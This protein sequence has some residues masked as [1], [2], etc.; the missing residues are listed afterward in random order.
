[1]QR[2]LFLLLLFSSLLACSNEAPV[3]SPLVDQRAFV[4]A[5]LT[6]VLQ[7]VDADDD[8]LRFG[9]A[10]QLEGVSSRARVS[11]ASGGKAKFHWTPLISDIGTWSFDFTVSDGEA[12]VRETIDIEV[13]LSGEGSTAPVFIQ[14]LGT[15]TTIDL[16]QQ[17]CVEFPVV[18]EDPDTAGVELGQ[19]EPLIVGAELRQTGELNGAW[20][21]CPTK[22][23]AANEDRYTL[24]LS[25]D[26]F[27]NET[28]V[29]QYLIVL[30]SGD[31]EGCPGEAP[32]VTHM[33]EGFDTVNDLT[34]TA[35]VSDDVGMKYE[36]LFYYSLTPPDNPPDL[37]AMTQ[38][39][40][41][42]LD[43]DLQ[44]GVWGAEVPNP[45]AA[46]PA[47]ASAQL[48]YIIAAQDNDDETGT[49]DHITQVPDMGAFKVTVTNPGGGG[50]LGLCEPCSADVQCGGQN[51]LCVVMGGE[52]RC[53][54]GCNGDSD[55]SEEGYY[56]SFGNMTS[57][58]N[59]SARQ[60]IPN[61]FMC[62]G[63]STVC[64]DD[65]FE[66]NDSLAEVSSGPALSVGTHNDLKSCPAASV[67]DDEDWFRLDL[68]TDTTISAAIAGGNTTDLDLALTDDQGNVI[69]TSDS[70]SST[71][72]V[73][74]CLPAGTYYLHVFAY[75]TG[76]NS[77]SLTYGETAGSCGGTCSDDGNE[78]DDSSISARSVDLNMGTYRSDTQAICSMDD[79][80][81]A[82]DMFAGEILYASLL[83]LQTSAAEDID[84]II[85][86][87]TLTNLTGCDEQ[88]PLLCDP[89]NGQSGT[90]NEFMAWP[91]SATGRYYVVIRGWNG[92]ENLYDVC[93]GLSSFSCP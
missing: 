39:S 76:E 20:S 57:V 88:N 17:S 52:P 46:E 29:K 18:V 58:D 71:E 73:A 50:G 56:C 66:D 38:V 28:T 5:E 74:S 64:N 13:A 75:G 21:F 44:S 2:A 16:E 14:P 49:C 32:V 3:L 77:Y 35:R 7:A 63:G 86:D 91:I 70:L 55:C 93:I 48:F 59:A 54:R 24:S 82:V 65:N 36:P 8:P 79:D 23:Q 42:L 10:S 25:A 67:G 85:Y 41:Q 30:R 11:D 78:D 53:M 47:G 43:G 51:D 62:D 61:D 37:S 27:E 89:L 84:I 92:A 26:D 34:I 83:F 80:W 87:D 45:V 33:P 69:E 9:F 4:N 72:S 15:G 81:Y 60:C 90:S 40:M 6:L 31:G 22:E 68:S 1:M 19:L 12:T